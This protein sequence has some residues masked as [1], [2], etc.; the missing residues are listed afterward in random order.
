MSTDA[1]SYIHRVGR[2]GRFGT[3]GITVTFLS[4]DE[5]QKVFDDVL[6]KY[7]NIKAEPLPEIIDKSIYSKLIFF[8]KIFSFIIFLG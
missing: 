2:A 1:E 8:N 7:P 4:S 6:K 5:D 3:K